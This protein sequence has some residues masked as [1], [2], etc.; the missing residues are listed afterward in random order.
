[1]IGH[2]PTEPQSVFRKV[3]RLTRP[4]GMIMKIA[5][6]AADRNFLSDD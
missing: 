2:P 1:M 5:V 3:R 6:D 4:G